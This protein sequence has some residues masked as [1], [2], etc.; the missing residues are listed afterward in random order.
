MTFFFPA[1]RVSCLVKES[2]FMPHIWDSYCTVLEGH[3]WNGAFLEGKKTTC[4]DLNHG[5]NCD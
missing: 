5:E 3:R 1:E 4:S 2:G